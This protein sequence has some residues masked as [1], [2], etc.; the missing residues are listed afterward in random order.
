[1]PSKRDKNKR[2]CDFYLNKDIKAQVQKVC[3]EH[4]LTLTEFLTLKIF[5]L[6]GKSPQEQW[7]ELEASDGRTKASKA[8]K[9]LQKET[10]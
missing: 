2:H 3:K 10:P 4:G 9:K 6:L 7:Q 1:M 5:E 8:K